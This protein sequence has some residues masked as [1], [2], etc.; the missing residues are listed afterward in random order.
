IARALLK[1]APVIL[2]DE[3]TASLDAENETKVQ[4]ALSR[5]VKGRTVL[6]IAHRMRTVSGADHV[7]LLKD[8][9][10]AEDGTP[11]ELLARGG[12]YARMVRLQSGGTEPQN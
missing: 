9:V 7:V 8:G 5:L 6:V 11:E 4:Q 2:L 10:V 3:A 12:I 1:N